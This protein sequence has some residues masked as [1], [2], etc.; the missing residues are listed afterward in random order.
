MYYC[1][2]RLHILTTTFSDAGSAAK[3]IV[4]GGVLV[5]LNDAE[6]Q[7]TGG[8]KWDCIVDNLTLSQL[9]CVEDGKVRKGSLGLLLAIM[10]S[11]ELVKLIAALHILRQV[12]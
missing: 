1:P 10:Q 2:V 4:L 6:K 7:R 12:K 11:I 5:T 9:K 8:E 3:H